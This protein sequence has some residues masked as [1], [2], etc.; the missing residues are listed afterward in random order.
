MILAWYTEVLE[1]NIPNSTFYTSDS[2]WTDLGLNQSLRGEPW[3]GLKAVKMKTQVWYMMTCTL[4]NITVFIF[5][6]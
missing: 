6:I 2:T 1:G 3:N 5:R 4:A